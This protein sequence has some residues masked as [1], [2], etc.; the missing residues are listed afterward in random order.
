MI[1]WL[2]VRGRWGKTQ[3]AVARRETRQA[4]RQY[5]GYFGGVLVYYTRPAPPSARTSVTPPLLLYNS[6]LYNTVYNTLIPFIPAHYTPFHLE[7]T[8]IPITPPLYTCIPPSGCSGCHIQAISSQGSNR[9]RA[10]RCAPELP[11]ARRPPLT[12]AG[13]WP[14]RRR[15]LV[16]SRRSRMTA[17]VPAHRHGE[18]DFIF[19]MS[20]LLHSDGLAR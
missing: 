17:G 1:S 14:R 15:S 7:Y 9:P 6:I 16:P 3:R 8:C 11:S 13:R 10:R 19:N 18:V 12:R 20:E 2:A 5:T 4:V